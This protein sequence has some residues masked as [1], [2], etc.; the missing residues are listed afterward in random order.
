MFAAGNDNVNSD[1]SP[2]YPCVYPHVSWMGRGRLKTLRPP[3]SWNRDSW[4][5]RWHLHVNLTFHW[6][7]STSETDRFT[8]VQGGHPRMSHGPSIVI[9]IDDLAWW[10]GKFGPSFPFKFGHSGGCFQLVHVE[11]LGGF[12]LKP[13]TAHVDPVSWR[14]AATPSSFL[15]S[16]R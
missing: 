16:V 2:F 15:G 9:R 10:F 11:F 3:Q 8:W 7:L 12:L 13:L 1:A 4:M 14:M 6:Q 5:I